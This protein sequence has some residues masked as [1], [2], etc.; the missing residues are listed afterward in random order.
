MKNHQLFLTTL[1]K[2][3]KSD[4]IKIGLFIFIGQQQQYLFLNTYFFMKF[5]ANFSPCFVSILNIYIPALK[6]IL[7][8]FTLSVILVRFCR[9]FI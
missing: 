7:L 8:L 1:P 4:K 9:F 6:F 2:I 3:K 5:S